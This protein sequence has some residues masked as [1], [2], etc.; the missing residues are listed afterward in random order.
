[1]P[2]VEPAMNLFQV[3][4]FVE[5]FPAMLGFY[6][7]T[8]GFEVNVIEPGPPSV[9]MVNWASLRTGGVIIE[10][11]DAATFWDSGLLKSANRDAVQLCFVVADVERERVR[12]EDA[13]VR[14]DPV[15]SERW[16]RYASFRDPEGNWLQIFEVFDRG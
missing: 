16:G 9:P 4:L 7:D 11:F 5:D 14:C 12:L 1:M 3:N 10:L 2:E 13:G 15:V 6:R 8:L